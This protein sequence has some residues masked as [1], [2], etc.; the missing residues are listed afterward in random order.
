MNN[1]DLRFAH[2]MPLFVIIG[3]LL[4]SSANVAVVSLLYLYTD[5]GIFLSG[6]AGTF[7]NLILHQFY[8]SLLLSNRVTTGIVPGY[9]RCAGYVTLSLTAGSVLAGLMSWVPCLGFAGSLVLVIAVLA[10]GSFLT[11]RMVVMSSADLAAVE[12]RDVGEDFYDSQTDPQAVGS[13]R[14]WFHRSRFRLVRRSVRNLYRDGMTIVDLG[15]GNCIWNEDRYPV[16]GLDT[17]ARMLRWAKE[18]GRIA[19]F[20]VCDDLGATGLPAGSADI[21]VMSEVLEHLPDVDAALDEV[22][23][24]LAPDGRCVITVP[25]DVPFGLFFLMFNLNCLYQWIVKGS[26]YHKYRCGHINHFGM[27]RLDR[28]LLEHGFRIESM[29]SPN[30]LTIICIASRS[31]ASMQSDQP[32]HS[33]VT[34]NTNAS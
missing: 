32:W 26:R 4:G 20:I 14:A 6:A 31:D 1:R 11:Y 16:L 7:V 25:Y 12:Y 17:N 5:A 18:R 29:K 19:T 13:V 28:L 8:Y 33:R 2:D 21:V 24:I 15:C 27:S 30:W 9:A 23:R 34:G 10:T 22:N 3:G